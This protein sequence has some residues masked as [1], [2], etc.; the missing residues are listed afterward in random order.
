MERTCSPHQPAP[1]SAPAPRA[2]A[3]TSA[4]AKGTCQPPK[5]SVTAMAD[6]TQRFP[7]STRKK[8]ANR[9]DEYSERYPATS[10][11]SASG[12]S[13]GVRLP[14]ASW[15]TKKIPKAT[16]AKGFVNACHSH[17]QAPWDRMIP[18]I[19][20]VP[21]ISTGTIAAMPAGIS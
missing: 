13:N 8:R 2:A 5:N 18:C 17:G 3:K 20:R 12:R 6:I 4:P 11:D 10:S 19:E 16:S 14:S 21:D 7:N 1:G 15:A 9:K